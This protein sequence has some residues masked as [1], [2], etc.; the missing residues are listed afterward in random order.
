MSRRG[1]TTP[2]WEK[3]SAEVGSDEDEIGVSE[4]ASR[5]GHLAKVLRAWSGS[6]RSGNKCPQELVQKLAEA[7][8]RVKNILNKLLKSGHLYFLDTIAES[9]LYFGQVPSAVSP[10]CPA[11]LEP[12]LKKGC[13]ACF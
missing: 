12:T 5:N 8:A 11:S 9:P 6:N 2:P 4:K 10:V 13:T 1:S 3:G 7:F